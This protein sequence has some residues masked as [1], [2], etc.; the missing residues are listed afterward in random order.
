MGAVPGEPVVGDFCP[1]CGARLDG[2]ERFCG[3][4]G[5]PVASGVS[6]AA[7]GVLEP[8][9]VAAQPLQHAV[10]DAPL[11]S[12][13]AAA[14]LAS[15]VAATAVSFAGLVAATVAI[16]ALSG[17]HGADPYLV[18]PSDLA[19]AL[20]VVGGLAAGFV[21]G[22]RRTGRSA[23]SGLLSAVVAAA[24]AAGV[25][26]F[27]GANAG[28]LFD[29]AL[30]GFYGLVD[31]HAGAAAGAIATLALAMLAGGVGWRAEA[32]GRRVAAAAVGS[33]VPVL[34]VAAPALW[35]IYVM[36]SGLGGP[37]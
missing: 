6:A 13:P 9:P 34:A 8:Q 30:G 16:H 32:A 27:L 23:Q 12:S 31:T 25:L 5:A 3:S 29:S 20:P 18:R 10:P 1:T 2:A 14:D 33:S 36:V 17:V 4:C 24:I 35:R 11:A 28:G 37:R 21:V 15:I 26:M 22:A 19:F 7:T